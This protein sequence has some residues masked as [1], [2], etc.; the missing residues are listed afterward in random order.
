MLEKKHLGDPFCNQVMRMCN[1]GFNE[2]I[3]MSPVLEEY[4]RENYPDYPI[5]S[6]TCKQ[7]ENIDGV[8]E[9][10]KKDYKYVVLD[11]NFNNC[12]D[13]LEQI[14]EKDRA[15]CEV[16][17]NACCTPKCKRR[18][19]HYRSIG[20]EQIAEW[21]HKKNMLSKKPYEA[22]GFA[23]EFMNN[24]PYAITDYVTYISPQAVFEKYLPMGFNNFKIE[25][26]TLPDICLLEYYI[27]YM[28][29]PE[30]QNK[31]RLDMLQA[32]TGKHKYFI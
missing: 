16:L 5:T 32:L 1:N 14:D 28:V 4:I 12:F 3:V 21:E 30:Y 22:K 19:E 7:I 15:R 25:G 8:K 10:L 29:K 17:V 6:S 26:R 20:L 9:E 13:Q 24:G 23:C 11:Y 31:I 27:I 18:G 2:A